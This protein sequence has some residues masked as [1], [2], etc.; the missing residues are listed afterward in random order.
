M[1]LAKAEKIQEQKAI[2]V[3]EVA[4]AKE[5]IERGQASSLLDQVNELIQKT[6][7]IYEKAEKAG[8]LRTALAAIRESRGNLELLGKLIGEL[9]DGVTV[10]IHNSPEWIELRT[11]IL[12]TLE[13]YP[14]A[15]EALIN[16][17]AGTT[18]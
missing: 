18:K 12:V 11:L 1:L 6:D 10:N 8:D 16:A 2:A 5:A 14:T 15:K 13:S 4:Q 9:Q 3:A 17:L 7:G